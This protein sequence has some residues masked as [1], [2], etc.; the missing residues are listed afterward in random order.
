M[1]RP[2]GE[3]RENVKTALDLL[4]DQADL[5]PTTPVAAAW[6]ELEELRAKAARCDAYEREGGALFEPDPVDEVWFDGRPDPCVRGAR[7]EQLSRCRARVEAAI[8]RWQDGYDNADL[9][10]DVR[11]ALR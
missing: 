9:V 8:K 10:R 6:V 4:L 7:L 1:I 3:P 5:D 2:A 11:E